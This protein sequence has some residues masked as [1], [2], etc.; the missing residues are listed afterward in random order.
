MGGPLCDP[1]YRKGVSVNQ[2][3][4]MMRFQGPE[5]QSLRHHQFGFE[6]SWLFAE[7]WTL[8]WIPLEN[9]SKLLGSSRDP[10]GSPIT[11]RIVVLGVVRKWGPLSP[12]IAE[13]GGQRV[14][15]LAGSG[16]MIL[17]G[18]ASCLRG[19]VFSWLHCPQL[20]NRQAQ[21]SSLPGE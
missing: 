5:K 15:R 9:E 10:K 19:G 2:E 12:H 21:F 13:P 11:T 1:G 16:S 4:L 20:C 14:Q 18:I 3:K 17:T 6:E 7:V 8:S